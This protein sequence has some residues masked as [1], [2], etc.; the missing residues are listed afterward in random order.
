MASVVCPALVRTCCAEEISAFAGMS[1]C[2]GG[3][4]SNHRPCAACLAIFDA[5]VTA[6]NNR[7]GLA[8]GKVRGFLYGLSDVQW[9]ELI[10]PLLSLPVPG[11]D[12]RTECSEASGLVNSQLVVACCKE[13][14]S[15]FT[16]LT[17]CASGVCSV[18]WRCASCRNIFAAILVAVNNQTGLAK[19]KVKNFLHSL[20]DDQWRELIGSFLPPPIAVDKPNMEDSKITRLVDAKLVAACCG[21]CD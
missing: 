10:G 13:E 2:Q 14:R 20:R 21:K 7:T 12:P 16:G 5:I 15:T 9:H 1:G 8:K 17:G 18:N 6:V 4:C 11:A 19:I 3:L